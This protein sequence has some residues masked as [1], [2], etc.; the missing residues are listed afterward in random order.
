MNGSTKLTLVAVLLMAS[1]LSGCA[2]WQTNSAIDRL[3][4]A[5]ADHAEALADGDLPAAR[6]TGLALL[7]QLAAY[8]DW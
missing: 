1:A 7:A 6:K 3:R 8:A 2:K 5:A 4:P